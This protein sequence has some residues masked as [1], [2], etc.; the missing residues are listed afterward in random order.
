MHSI[1]ISF[2]R[3]YLVGLLVSSNLAA[4]G[5]TFAPVQVYPTGVKPYGLAVGDLTGDGYPD[6]V[7][8][9]YDPGTIGLLINQRNGTFVPG[10]FYSLPSVPLAVALG[11]INNDGYL[12]IATANIGGTSASVL[13]NQQNG[14]FAPASTYQ[15]GSYSFPRGVALGDLNK[16]G[17]LD[18]V[19]ANNGSGTAGVLLNQRDGSFAPVTEY[20]TG[21]G[22]PQNVA[23]S[24]VN[25]DGYLDVIMANYGSNVPVPGGNTAGVLLNRQD[26]TFAPV[27]LYDAG[28]GPFGLGVADVDKDGHPDLVFSNINSEVSVLRNRQDGTFAPPTTYTTGPLNFPQC[29]ATDDLNGDTFP[30][31]VTAGGKGTADVLRNQQNGTFAPVQTYLGTG[32]RGFGVAVHDVN[33]DNKPDILVTDFAS[34][35][36]GVLLNTTDFTAP[37]LARISPAAAGAGSQVT[38]AGTRLLQ[39]QA[40]HF[41]GIAATAFTVL[42]ATQLVATVPPSATS[43]LVTITTPTGTTEGVPFTVSTPL[44][45]TPAVTP[46]AVSVFP[47]PASGA[48]TVRLASGMG[49]RVVQATLCNKLGQQVAQHT[50]TLAA[51]ETS[52]VFPAVVLAPG[53]YN[54]RIQT[55]TILLNKSVVIY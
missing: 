49:P 42:S 9:N 3:W 48:F 52:F 54:V 25:H 14:T 15:V 47:N 22:N 26:G 17:Y 36:L 16:D 41:N 5:Q 51:T 7:T 24:D 50:A 32:N 46:A 6:V 2:P 12:D 40:V 10:P 1:F 44:A 13:L 23:L 35:S 21:F 37:L 38:L 39:T 45:T 30:D 43:G 34:N 18:L 8:A 20:P 28:I 53:L 19:T 33:L 4:A 29:L 55:G 31:I 11:D 27:Q